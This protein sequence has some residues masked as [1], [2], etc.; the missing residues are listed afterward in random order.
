MKNVRELG[1]FQQLLYL[2][3]HSLDHEVAVCRFDPF[4]ERHKNAEAKAVDEIE[5][6]QIQGVIGPITIDQPCQVPFDICGVERLELI[7]PDNIDVNGMPGN[8][9]YDL[10]ATHFRF[11]SS[12]PIR[13]AYEFRSLFS[14]DFPP[15]CLDSGV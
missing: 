4:Q 15:S 2:G 11:F 6:F 1:E 12:K 5:I 14:G 7:S 8:I 10:M 13:A 3:I 9:K